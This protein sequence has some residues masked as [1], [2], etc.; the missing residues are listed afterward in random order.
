MYGVYFSVED[1]A[2]DPGVSNIRN[3]G[4][5][6]S[7]QTADIRIASYD[8]FVFA[9]DYLYGLK[10]VREIDTYYTELRGSYLTQILSLDTKVNTEGYATF[11]YMYIDEMHSSF[12]SPSIYA[13]PTDKY[14]LKYVDQL[15]RRQNVWYE[16]Y[17]SVG[18]Y[19][20][21][22]ANTFSDG[23]IPLYR[24]YGDTAIIYL[25][26]FYTATV[27]EPDGKDSDMMMKEAM[28]AIT[29]KPEIKNIIIDLSYNTGGNVGALLRVLGYMTNELIEY[30]GYNALTERGYILYEAVDTL[31][32]GNYGEDNYD[33]Y[34]WFVLSSSVS[35]S[36]ANAMVSIVK[37]M[38]IATIIGEK[39]GGG[40]SSIVPIVLAD[41]TTIILSSNSTM[42]FAVKN[43]DGTFTFSSVEN[44]V[45]PDYL[46]KRADFYNDA[47]LVD[48][49][50]GLLK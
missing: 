44:G 9:L 20:S 16:G 39:S 13:A 31:D 41:G 37:Q 19:N 22:K 47:K 50:H 11:V 45:E 34:N 2:N 28:A 14:D 48:F 23:N 33:Q 8:S 10:K 18:K 27:D 36:A 29:S 15:G 32:T 43:S 46:Y 12:S 1:S 6:A 35:F 21:D 3:N 25:D 49:I 7:D 40:G 17:F 24:F 30:T 26:G 5:S 38:G 42:A 4:L